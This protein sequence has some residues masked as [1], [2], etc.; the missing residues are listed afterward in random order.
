MVPMGDLVFFG[1]G[2]SRA[3][4][5]PTM[6]EM[7]TGFENGIKESETELFTYYS[8]IKKTLIET[9]GSNSIDI[10]AMFSVLEG[11]SRNLESK[12][13][14]H[15]AFYYISKTSSTKPFDSKDIEMAKKLLEKLKE[16]L[17]NTCTI[18][19]TTE[20]STEIYQKSYVP[21]FSILKGKTIQAFHHGK[22]NLAVDWKCYTTNYD[23]VFENFWNSLQAPVDH[24]DRQ[25][26]SDN[27]VFNTHKLELGNHSFVKL[28]GSLDW[29]KYKISGDVI[30]K[31]IAAFQPDETEG[32]VMLFPIQQKD[33]YLFPWNSLFQDFKRGLMVCNKWYVVGYAFND[34]FIRNVFIEELK[35][36]PNPT[37]VIIGPS[38]DQIVQKF[39]QEFRDK[40]ISLPIKFGS[41]YF[42]RQIRDFSEGV[43]TL[44]IMVKT[45]CPMIGFKSSI[46]LIGGRITKINGD[47]RSMDMTPTK[48]WIETPGLP[49]EEKEVEIELKIQHQPPFDKDLELQIGFNGTYDYEFGVYIEDHFLNSKS[50][51]TSTQDQQFQKHLSEAMFISASSLFVSF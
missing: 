17:K 24:F 51:N 16:Y 43:R 21:L 22:Y 1:A 19:L 5:I 42:S 34:E 49:D 36:K 35:L 28:H 31:K 30:R 46:P 20:K 2:A 48:E 25:G 33:L 41:K 13:L 39:P 23:A 6:Q 12:D 15:F 32:D 11:I 18:K 50:G 40:I 44:K 14:G 47:P 9:F 29:T 38:S 37:L 8:E 10:E 45:H 26:E 3:F 27:Y 7:V 4:E